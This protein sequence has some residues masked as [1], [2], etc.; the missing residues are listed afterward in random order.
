M[1][2]IQE[3]DYNNHIKNNHALTKQQ[4]TIHVMDIWKRK[5]YNM[6]HH[7]IRK[8]VKETTSCMSTL[9]SWEDVLGF[10]EIYAILFETLIWAAT[11]EKGSENM[12]NFRA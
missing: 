5:R 12:G 2:D 11:L 1:I 7:I 3:K 10:N 9:C 4:F 8:M 6:H